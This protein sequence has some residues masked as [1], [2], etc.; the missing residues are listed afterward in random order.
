MKLK[1][2]T[3]KYEPL[4]ANYVDDLPTFWIVKETSYFGFSLFFELIGRDRYGEQPF[5]SIEEM[6]ERIKYLKL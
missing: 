2:K 4:I 3:V 6:E 5:L 1:I